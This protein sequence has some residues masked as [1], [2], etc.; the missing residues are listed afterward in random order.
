[1]VQLTQSRD[2]QTRSV[3]CSQHT[4]KRRKKYMSRWVSRT[5]EWS[6]KNKHTP[7]R[8]PGAAVIAERTRLRYGS[9]AE[10]NQTLEQ[11]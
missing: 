8:R 11:K 9:R 1:M 2:G 3:Q 4:Q 5:Q 7:H 6:F 10:E